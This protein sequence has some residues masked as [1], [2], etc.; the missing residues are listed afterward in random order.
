MKRFLL[1]ILFLPVSLSALANVPEAV[2]DGRRLI[3]E[4]HYDAAIQ[5]LQGVIPEATEIPAETERKQA[6][7]AIHFYS[8]L[9]F[10]KLGN[11]PKAREQLEEHFTFAGTATALDPA[12]YEASFI[13]LFNDVKKQM[14][15]VGPQTRF[16]VVYPG[17]REYSTQK[18]RERP[19]SE[20]DRSPEFVY[21][22]T[23]DEQDG[24]RRLRDD[25]ARQ[26][27][28]DQFWSSRDATFRNEFESRVAFADYAF[29]TEQTRGSLSDRGQVFVLLGKP[30]VVTVKNLTRAEG[31]TALRTRQQTSE[32]TVERWYFFRDQLPQEFQKSEVVFKFISQPG[33]GSA[34]LS[35][36][37]FPLKTLDAARRR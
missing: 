4:K 35:R 37:V 18:P 3:Q 23:K 19:I 15:E 34:I 25:P 29:G 9:A 5:R 28:V 30:R 24:F 31:A 32:G 11:E 26:V 6:F 21:L 16:D 7:S 17:F 33:Y 14:P 1:L 36:D 20:W 10:F 27:Y 8:G 2:A 12:K 13:R 22:A